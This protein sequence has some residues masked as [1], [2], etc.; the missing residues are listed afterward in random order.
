MLEQLSKKPQQMNFFSEDGVPS[1]G[2]GTYSFSPQYLS[3]GETFRVRAAFIDELA[4]RSDLYPGQKLGHGNTP[5]LFRVNSG[6]VVQTGPDT[7][8]I[9]PHAGPIVPQGNPWEPTIVAYN[10]GDQT[11]RPTERPAHINV[12]IINTAGAAQ[13]LE[14]PPLSDQADAS[15]APIELAAKASSGLPVQYFVVSGPAQI[16]ANGRTLALL[17]MPPRA[18]YPVEVIVS[19]FQW[20]RAVAPLVKSAGPVTRSFWIRQASPPPKQ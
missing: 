13:T 18:R 7:F 9:R 10:L 3:D 15:A 8:R 20:G 12:S 11:Y 4:V 5:I 17:P 14:F 16:A 2:G 19:A 1:T 6:A